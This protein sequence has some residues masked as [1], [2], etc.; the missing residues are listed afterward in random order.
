MKRAGFIL[1]LSTTA[2]GLLLLQAFSPNPEANDHAHQ[3]ARCASDP[4]VV[5]IP[6]G[7]VLLGEDGPDFP[8]R[9]VHVSSFDIDRH[10]VTNRQFAA[11]VEAAGYVTEAEKDG[12]GAVFVQPEKVTSMNIVQWWRLVEGADWR[13][14]TGPESTIEDA[15]DAPVVQVT[16]ADASAYAAWAGRALPTRAQWERAA[17]GDQAH[18]R[19]PMNWAYDSASRAPKANTWQGIFPVQNTREDGFE[20]LAPVGC[21]PPNEFG[22]HDMIGNVWEWTREDAN[23]GKI[24]RGGSFLCATN[25]CMNFRPAGFQAQ[26]QDLPTSHIGFRTVSA[27][28]A[29]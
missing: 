14:P 28:P 16:F 5:Q 9:R 18:P 8:G 2:A 26:E 20:G 19:H 27:E 10:E 1:F 23:S 15:M 21:F 22:V 11:F 13:H 7:E 24:I 4:G 12:A 17:R 25:F 3:T 29:K 6:E